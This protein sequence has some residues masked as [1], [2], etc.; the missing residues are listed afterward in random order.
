[1]DKIAK[2][3]IVDDDKDILKILEIKLRKEGFSV[4]TETSPLEALELLSLEDFDIVLLDQRMPEI[5]GIEFLEHIKLYEKDIPVI[6][7]TAYGDIKDAVEAIKKGAFH[8][9]TKPIDFEELKIILEKALNWQDLKREIN[10]LKEL[11]DVDIIAKSSQM[12]NILNHINKIAPFDINVLISGESGTGKEVVAR[13]I[14]KKSKR[15]NKPFIAVNCGAIPHDLLESELFGFKKGA[16]TG[17]T[18][19]KKGI[20]EEAQGGTVFLDEIGDLPLDL[21]V[22]LLRVLQ[23]NEIK[24]L[25]SNKPKKVNV[26]FIAATNKDLKKLVKEG[27]FREDLYYRLNVISIDIPPLRK[28]KEDIL[29]LA[30]FFLKKYSL[31]YGIPQKRFSESAKAQMLSYD[32]PGNVRE[33][34]HAIERTLLTTNGI[35]IKKIEG[36]PIPKSHTVI[37]PYKEAK[38]E[39]EKN[40][41]ENLLKETN[42]NISKAAKLAQKTRAEIYRMIKKYNLEKS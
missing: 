17:A 5:S 35:V 26:R 21:Q 3:L 2:I 13:Y 39:F 27:K 1:M 38:E 12:K 22:K 29:P 19:D 4:K 20:I 41:L 15:K 14:H 9:I 23:E 37:K 24:P 40:Y 42:W 36:I 6:I 25:G 8:F 16:F 32:W 28:R 7:M 11:V 34:E 33:L 18:I 30:E 31:K 10:E